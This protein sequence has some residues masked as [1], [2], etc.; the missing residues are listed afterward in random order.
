MQERVELC[1]VPSE[2]L[3]GPSEHDRPD[4]GEIE[5][6]RLTVPVKPL[7]LTALIVVFPVEPTLRATFTGLAVSTKSCAMNSTEAE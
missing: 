2:K 4:E 6:L 1:D 7:A 5:E 3:A